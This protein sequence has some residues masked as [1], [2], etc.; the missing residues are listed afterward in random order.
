MDAQAKDDGQA[1]AEEFTEGYLRLIGTVPSQGRV[2]QTQL[3]KLLQ[4]QRARH[5]WQDLFENHL[6]QE[7]RRRVLEAT[8]NERCVCV[9]ALSVFLLLHCLLQRAH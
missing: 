4:G 3:R 5:F 7:E 9:R 1:F 8:G 2:M 6:T